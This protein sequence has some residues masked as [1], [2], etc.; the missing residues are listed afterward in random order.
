MN[1]FI[2]ENEAQLKKMIK[3]KVPNAKQIDEAEMR[4]WVLNDEGIYNWARSQG[5]NI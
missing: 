1:K 3:Q 5:V 4:L 2:R